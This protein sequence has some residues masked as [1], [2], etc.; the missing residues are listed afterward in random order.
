MLETKMKSQWLESE[1]F[2]HIKVFNN[3]SSNIC[4]FDKQHGAIDKI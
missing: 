3:Y 1:F 4:A 2:I